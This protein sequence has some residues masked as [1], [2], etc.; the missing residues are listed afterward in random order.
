MKRVFAGYGKVN[1]I[2]VSLRLFYRD[3]KVQDSTNLLISIAFQL[4]YKKTK[5]DHF[6]YLAIV[7]AMNISVNCVMSQ[8]ASFL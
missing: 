5:T 3:F 1:T 6:L 2:Y 7:L 8:G 4:C